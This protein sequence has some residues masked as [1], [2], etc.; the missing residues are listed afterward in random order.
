[1]KSPVPSATNLFTFLTQRFSASYDILGCS[2]LVHM[3]NP[4][5]VTTDANGVATAAT[6]N[7][8]LY[9]RH[10]ANLKAYDQVDNVSDSQAPDPTE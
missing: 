2:D 5:S 7:L 1:M 3:D 6:I 9:K 8:P 4:I 10:Q